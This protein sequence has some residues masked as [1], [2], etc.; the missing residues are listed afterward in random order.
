[1]RRLILSTQKQARFFSF[2]AVK[3]DIIKICC[4][5]N[6][7]NP[8]NFFYILFY[9]LVCQLHFHLSTSYFHSCYKIF[10]SQ[11]KNKVTIYS[12][13]DFSPRNRKAWI[14]VFQILK[15][16]LLS[17]TFHTLFHNQSYEKAEKNFLE[18]TF[19]KTF[20]N[21]GL[22]AIIFKWSKK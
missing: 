5:L 14:N 10:P 9:H 21:F 15:S 4:L 2:S 16:L 3:A 17:Y 1:M 8:V 6:I 7:I 22:W 20:W 12:F 19:L 11:T 18:F 13:P